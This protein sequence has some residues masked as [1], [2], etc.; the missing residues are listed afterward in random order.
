M[1]PTPSVGAEVIPGYRL[2]ERIGYGGY[3]EV[4]KVTVPGGL[5]KA[6][7]IVYGDLTGP[8]AEQEFKSLERIKGARHPFLLS[9]ERFE[10]VEGRLLIFT[11][12]A[13][14]SLFQRFRECR[15][16]GLPGIPRDELLGHLRDAAEALDYM[17]ETHG[18]Q[19]L[20]VK[21]EN[22]LL[23]SG[24]VKVADF[25]LVKE[26]AGTGTHITGGIT[27]IYAAPEAFDGRATRQSDQY[28]LAIV[29][30]EMLTGVRPFPGTTAFQLAAQHTCAPPLLDSLPPQDRPILS[31][32]L[33]KIPQ[34][35]F[36]SCQELIERLRD[37]APQAVGPQ[38]AENLLGMQTALP[39]RV[40]PRSKHEGSPS[41]SSVPAP[42][43]SVPIDPDGMRPTL[44]VGIGGLGARV[45]KSL[46]KL[47][48]RQYGDLDKMG[49]LRMLLLDTDRA[50]LRQAQQGRRAEALGMAE[51]LH[52][53]LYPPEHY[54]EQAPSLQR[55]IDRRF[56]FGIP[57]SL[58]TEG[59]RPL[60]RLALI[61]NAA[62]FLSALR[63]ATG[64]LASREAKIGAVGVTTRGLRTEVP[65]VFVVASISGAT[66]GGMLIDAAYAVR[67]VL[68][69][70]G[71]PSDDL[72]GL[73]VHTSGP[74]EDEI[75]RARINAFAT[76]RELRHWSRPDA[77]YP[78]SPEHSLDPPPPGCPPFGDV[79]LLAPPAQADPAGQKALTDRLAE[80]LL[81][82]VTN[83]V[84]LDRLRFLSR[85]EAPVVWRG[86]GLSRL[87][88]P[89]KALTEWVDRV[90][91]RDLVERWRADLAQADRE[92]LDKECQDLLTQYPIEE[93]SL[94]QRIHGRLLAALDGDLEQAYQQLLAGVLSTKEPVMPGTARAHE[95][96]ARIEQH[97]GAGDDPDGIGA[98]PP[99]ALERL[100]EQE[101]K[102]LGGELARH[103]VGW[104]QDVVET[105]GLRTRGAGFALDLLVAKV[106][107]QTRN[108][109]QRAKELHAVG[110]ALRQR[111][112][113][114]EGNSRLS[115]R[116]PAG[117]RRLW[118]ETA[119]DDQLY[120]GYYCVR[121]QELAY[122]CALTAA[123]VVRGALSAWGQDLNQARRKLAEFSERMAVRL[124][125]SMEEP[126]P[127]ADGPGPSQAALRE[128]LPYG[129]E[130]LPS[131]VT[132]V[133]AHLPVDLPRQF[134]LLL[135]TEVLD[136]GGGLWGL[137]T[138]KA[139]VSR[140]SM[141][142]SPA[143]VAFWDL[144]CREQAAGLQHFQTELMNWGRTLVSGFLE[145]TDLI[146][147]LLER[148]GDDEAL[149]QFVRDQ[150]AAAGEGLAR[151]AWEHLLLV[152]PESP[153][154]DVLQ[155]QAIEALVGVP[156]TVRET[157]DSLVT[158]QE[159]AHLSLDSVAAS[160]SQNDP[161]LI[162]LAGQL[163]TR[164]DV[165]WSPLGEAQAGP[166]S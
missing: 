39:G 121:L 106:Q 90:L 19:H 116:I 64:E 85:D 29:Y 1:P 58:Q 35:R 67:Q 65:R 143:S 118:G 77:Q 16:S 78:G 166:V 110:Q 135:Q 20:D 136:A 155:E 59:L 100:P 126:K 138:G 111:I 17:S 124:S 114:T 52:C 88:F 87:R 141:S 5:D 45:L 159:N 158:V 132:A 82:D 8:R 46:K 152:I 37:A 63:Q 56:L 27:P 66:G 24:R 14:R 53:P 69:E 156:M 99:V 165:E 9:L 96:L 151:G 40:T 83:G 54:R 153:D 161:A 94:L 145:R 95:A 60:G 125:E 131:A 71:L 142:R 109:H 2:V 33:S 164:R 104:L 137:L 55:W 48:V 133:L 150:V 70:F 115:V 157:G 25:G 22:L 30:Q 129:T 101:G 50:S 91:C 62:Y 4:W 47:L 134:D 119:R 57:R 23:L 72:A 26:V 43:P 112:T 36:A 51:V 12:L 10:A 147:L 76:L 146:G 68:G 42:T 148:Y 3:G 97:L 144:V 160:L 107:D 127:T 81:F 84:A 162:D 44:F 103:F 128:M 28:S 80:Y 34:Q 49:I 123:Q 122:G 13:D 38:P 93:D 31:R 117:V 140:L 79:Y 73:L 98:R 41:R 108:L 74:K 130:N 163:L 105:P 113:T 92:R 6:V 75:T 11:E 18:L 32:A 7:K 86:C 89:R 149:Q 139:D 15:T 120:W 61:D 21:P 102:P 154:S